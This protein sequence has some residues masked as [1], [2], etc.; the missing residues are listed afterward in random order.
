MNEATKSERGV[1]RTT[2]RAI[3]TLTENIKINVPRI[4]I[5]PV[6]NWVKPISRPS[7]S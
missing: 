6:K 2:I 1:R 5:T 4:V 3:L 7:E